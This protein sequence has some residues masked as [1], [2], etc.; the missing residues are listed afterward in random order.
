MD[1]CA[2]YIALLVSMGTA[3]IDARIE[4]CAAVVSA[5]DEAGENVNHFVELAWVESNFTWPKNRQGPL[6]ASLDYWPGERVQAG[7]GAWQYYRMRCKGRWGKGCTLEDI[8]C[9]YN[10]GWT[11]YTSTGVRGCAYSRKFRSEK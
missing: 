3:D 11:G 1:P 2:P 5:A 10:M 9:A 6:Q 8:R 4:T 7:I